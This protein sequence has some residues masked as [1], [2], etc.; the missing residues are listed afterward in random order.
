MGGKSTFGLKLLPDPSSSYKIGQ[1]QN[2]GLVNFRWPYIEYTLRSHDSR[3]GLCSSISFVGNE[4]TAFQVLRL[5]PGALEEVKA[6]KRAGRDELAR[7]GG[8]S[9]FGAIDRPSSAHSFRPQMAQHVKVKLGGYIRIN[10]QC[11]NH[12]T[13]ESAIYAAESAE[14]GLSYTN[15]NCEKKLHMQYIFPDIQLVSQH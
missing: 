12:W 14:T 7:F 15:M 11:Q 2:Q 3:N 4:G 10:C 6:T 1:V 13:P 5:E 8:K 9:H